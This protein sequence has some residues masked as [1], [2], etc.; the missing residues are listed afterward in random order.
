MI[1]LRRPRAGRPAYIDG[2]KQW[3]DYWRSRTR[4]RWRIIRE[5]A[6]HVAHPRRLDEELPARGIVR[7]RRP[8]ARLRSRAAARRGSL[9]ERQSARER[10]LLPCCDLRGLRRRVRGRDRIAR[11]GDRRGDAGDGHVPARRDAREPRTARQLPALQPD[12][13]NNSNRWQDV[14]DVTDRCV[15]ADPARRTITCRRTGA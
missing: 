10:R 12:D 15:S 6:S 9:H 8:P 3:E 13:E 5:K 4:C 1:V 14:L 2:R 7:R 11:R